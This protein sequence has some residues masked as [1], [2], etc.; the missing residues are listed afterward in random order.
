MNKFLTII[1]STYN[2]GNEFNQTAKSIREQTDNDYQW[3]VI[4]GN[5]SEN[6]KKIISQN[7]DVIDYYISENDAGI[8]DAWNKACEQIQGEWVIFLGAGDSF[9]NPDLVSHLKKLLNVNQSKLFYG[10]VNI[11]DNNCNIICQRGFVQNIVWYKGKPNM[12]CHQGVIQH[13]SLFRGRKSFDPRY[14]IAG[15]TKFLMETNSL[16]DI[17]YLD[18]TISNMLEQGIS[19]RPESKLIIYKEAKMLE[20]DF[21]FKTNSL[22][23]IGYYLRIHL[24]YILMC[25]MP[26]KLYHSLAK[27]RR[28]ITGD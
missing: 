13:Y 2:V 20:A 12:P 11:V 18:Y 17:I 27:I 16:Q 4:D 25:C 10:K 22:H 9:D 24:I 23:K 28:K 15:D 8:Y 7:M 5:S 19:G 3:I 1:T 14:K 26:L 21:K 6:T